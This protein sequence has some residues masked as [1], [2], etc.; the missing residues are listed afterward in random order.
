MEK[1][2]IELFWVP[3]EEMFADRFT[4]PPIR[5]VFQDKQARI[6]VVNVGGDY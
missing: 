1:G 2:L 5:P 4:K 6:G 3:G